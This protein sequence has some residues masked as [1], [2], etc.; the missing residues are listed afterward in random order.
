MAAITMQIAM[1]CRITR[2]RIKVWLRLGLPP[3][4]MFHSPIK[5][6]RATA[7]SANGTAKRTACSMT[8]FPSVQGM[9]EN[10][11]RASLVACHNRV[12][13]PCRQQS[14]EQDGSISWDSEAEGIGESFDGELGGAIGPA[15]RRRHKAKHRRAKHET[16][17][18][19]RPHRR[20]HVRSE[21]EPAEQ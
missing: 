17:A 2:Q 16:P 13:G 18:T 5:S 10:A 21:I 11:W 15:I 19:I 14:A 20:D 7:A 9:A 3:R 4:S 8:G 12:E 6:T 1:N